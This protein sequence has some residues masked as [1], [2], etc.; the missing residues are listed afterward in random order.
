MQE[1]DREYQPSVPL[2]LYVD[3]MLEISRRSIIALSVLT[4]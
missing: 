1:A 2:P 3:S 4:G